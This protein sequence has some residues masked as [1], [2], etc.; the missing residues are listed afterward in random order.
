MFFVIIVRLSKT[1]SDELTSKFNI[2]KIFKHT[3]K[4][5]ICE[6]IFTLEKKERLIDRAR[7]SKRNRYELL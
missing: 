7:D 2:E 4:I 1:L 5:T 3:P 6:N